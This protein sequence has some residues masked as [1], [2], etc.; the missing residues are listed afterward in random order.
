MKPEDLLDYALGQLD[1]PHR[2]AIEAELAIDPALASRADRLGFA[3]A[4]GFS[5]ACRRWFREPE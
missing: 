2:E 4:T 1:G 5:R 3:D